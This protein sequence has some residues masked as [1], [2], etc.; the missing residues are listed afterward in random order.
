MRL[1]VNGDSIRITHMGADFVFVDAPT[2]HP[3]GEASILMEVDERESRWQ[4]S[5]PEGMSTTSKR[6]LLALSK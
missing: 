6:V 4:V 2:D 1:I 5:L 3:P